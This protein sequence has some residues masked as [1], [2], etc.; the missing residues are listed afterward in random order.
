MAERLKDMSTRKHYP[1]RHQISIIV[2][3]IEAV[4]TSFDLEK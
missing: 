3:G 2:N 1:G 4:Q